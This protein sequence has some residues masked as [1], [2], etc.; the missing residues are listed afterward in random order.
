MKPEI[1]KLWVEALLSGEYQQ[2]VNTLKTNDGKFC[3]LGVLCDLHA[4]Q[5]GTEWAENKL[6]ENKFNYF[7]SSCTLPTEVYT[8]AG[9]KSGPEV[10]KN[11]SVYQL[12]ILNDGHNSNDLKVERHDFKQIAEL[13]EQQL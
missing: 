5:T 2:G 12:A 11:G 8:W 9:V 7:G 13:I 4:K 6:S 3:C 10:R 1:K